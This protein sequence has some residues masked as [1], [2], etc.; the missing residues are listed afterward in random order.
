MTLIEWR[1]GFNT[2]IA[3]VDQEHRELVEMINAVFSLLEGEPERENIADC[4]GD[5]YG[6]VSAHFALEEQLMEKYEYG[7]YDSHR[8]DHEKLLEE[9]G[10]ISERFEETESFDEAGLR[11]ALNEWFLTHFQTHDARLHALETLISQEEKRGLSLKKILE[12][13]RK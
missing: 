1:E 10:E 9:I 2:G 13:L 7:E 8:K 11:L 4:L 3:G 5:I 6:K 12:K